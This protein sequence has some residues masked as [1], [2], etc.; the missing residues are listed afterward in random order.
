MGLNFGKLKSTV[1]RG[2]RVGCGRCG[3]ELGSIK[4]YWGGL[5]TYAHA[6]QTRLVVL[7]LSSRATKNQNAVWMPLFFSCDVGIA[8]N[9][10]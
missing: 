4:M 10:T 3:S 6:L 1:G 8:G 7:C 9:L 2:R 5:S